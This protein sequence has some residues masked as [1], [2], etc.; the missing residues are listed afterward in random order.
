MK[1]LLVMILGILSIGLILPFSVNAAC[2]LTGQ[3]VRVYD[4][5]TSSTAYMKTSPLSTVYFLTGTTD[6]DLRDALRNCQNS[7][8]RCNVIGSAAVCPASGSIG[9]ATAVTVNP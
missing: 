8:Q 2:S 5:A 1:K 6:S 9:T 4:T 7:D 3:V